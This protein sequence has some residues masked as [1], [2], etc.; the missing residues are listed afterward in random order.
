MIAIGAI[1]TRIAA[2]IVIY[3]L[4]IRIACLTAHHI[5]AMATI[6]RII[7]HHALA[8]VI[9]ILLN[10]LFLRWLLYL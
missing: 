9:I 6:V 8:L 1:F 2:D 3:V 7:G 5:A 4:V 10:G